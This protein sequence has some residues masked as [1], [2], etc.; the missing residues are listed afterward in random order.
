MFELAVYVAGVMADFRT[1]YAGGVLEGW[2]EPDLEEFL[3]D[4]VPRKVGL[5]DDDIEAAPEA[6]SWV[7][8]SSARAVASSSTLPSASAFGRSPCGP[9]SRVRLATRATSVSPSR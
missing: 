3:L 1:S 2:N 6:V 7:L 4:W 8:R 5:E 9:R